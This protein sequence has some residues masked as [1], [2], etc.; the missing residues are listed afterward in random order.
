MT[1]FLP[2]DVSLP[3]IGQGAL[4]LEARR[5]DEFVKKLVAKLEHGPTR[6]GINAE[7]AFLARLEGGCQV[8]IA[9]HAVVEDERL[10]LDGLIAS[11]DGQRYVRET[12]SGA[13]KEA[14]KL[15][16]ELAERLLASGG[17]P[18]LQEIYGTA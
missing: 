13:T 2:P 14:E 1:E 11:V 8:P 10:T 7:R 9:G 6:I 12:I 16:L 18:I 17:R 5:D 4:G 3:A 15:G